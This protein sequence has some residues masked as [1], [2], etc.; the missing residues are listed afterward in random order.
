[1]VRPD[2]SMTDPGHDSCCTELTGGSPVA[3]SAGAPRSRPRAMR[4]TS[5]SE[6]GVESP[7]GVIR[8]HGGGQVR[9]PSESEPYSLET[10]TAE[11]SGGRAAHVT[12]KARDCICENIRRGAGRSRGMGEGMRTQFG[13]E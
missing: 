7:H 12:A 4:E 9:R 10:E 3:A 2:E 11:R 13:V 6:W 1:M 5:A 8:L